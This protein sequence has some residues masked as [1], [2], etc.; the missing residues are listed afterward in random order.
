MCPLAQADGHDGP[1][2]ISGLVPRRTAVIENVGVGREYPVGD[3]VLP[4]KLPD[5]L[6]RV[7]L[8]GFC[9]QRH[10]GDVRRHLQPG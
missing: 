4:H 10:Q 5:V 6:H 7:Q 2:L 8:G 3:P 9:R 1:G